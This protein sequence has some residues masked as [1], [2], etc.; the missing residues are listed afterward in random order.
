MRH[1]GAQS[2]KWRRAEVGGGVAD[3]KVNC[4]RRTVQA[5]AALGRSLGSLGLLEGC[6]RLADC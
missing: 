5:F 2:F 3:T 1:L 4:K 6:H